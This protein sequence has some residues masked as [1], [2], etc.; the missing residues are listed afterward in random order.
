MATESLD[1]ELEELAKELESFEEEEE[2]LADSFE[3]DEFEEMGDFSASSPDKSFED[4]FSDFDDEENSYLDEEIGPAK[5]SGKKRNF[6]LL[7]GIAVLI[8]GLLGGGALWM[9]IDPPEELLSYVAQL[10]EDRQDGTDDTESTEESSLE[11]VENLIS[12]LPDLIDTVKTEIEE[13]QEELPGKSENVEAPPPPIEKFKYFVQVARCLDQT[14]VEN[15]RTLLKQNGLRPNVVTKVESTP[16]FEVVSRHKFNAYKAAQWSRRINESYHV[17]GEAF[18]QR[19][20]TSYRI[21][22]GLFPDRKTAEY[23]TGSLNL[24]FA[25]QLQFDIK[26]S[27]QKTLYYLIRTKS[28]DSREDALALQNH[29]MEQDEQFDRVWIITK[30]YRL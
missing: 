28:F 13:I 3:D 27:H 25:G 17:T 1:S 15:F 2:L 9:T 23:V 10:L 26:S 5:R 14:C 4:D 7:V 24:K 22:M 12:E 19:E 16:V 18:R 29:L 11:Q 30:A 20:G 6:L 21:S 8:G